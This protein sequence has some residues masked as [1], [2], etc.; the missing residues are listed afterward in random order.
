MEMFWK[1][2]RET[3]RLNVCAE[4]PSDVY[5]EGR[6]VVEL[7]DGDDKLVALADLDTGEDTR[8]E[9]ERA[10][11]EPTIGQVRALKTWTAPGCAIVVG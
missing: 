8:P 9:S 11:V 5:P 7:R 6:A 1:I 3:F 4:E 10:I 2:D